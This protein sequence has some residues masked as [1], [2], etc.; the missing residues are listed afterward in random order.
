M[1]LGFG[2]SQTRPPRSVLESSCTA[3]VQSYTAALELLGNENPILKT[4][5]VFER[6]IPKET[7][8]L[9]ASVF[10]RP[11]AA[12]IQQVAQPHGLHTRFGVC[13]VEVCVLGTVGGWRGHR[14][15]NERDIVQSGDPVKH[16]QADLGQG[17]L[18]GLGEASQLDA[19]LVP[20]GSLVVQ[21]PP[22]HG[23]VWVSSNLKVH[24]CSS[25]RYS[26]VKM[27]VRTGGWVCAQPSCRSMTHT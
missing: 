14:A 6:P 21:R 17:D 4:M 22:D 26:R 13:A 24:I 25:H 15:V 16:A 11:I 20:V 3:P 8:K 27:P 7:V 12:I 10:V 18:E 23:V 5:A 19:G 1:G 2:S 9:T